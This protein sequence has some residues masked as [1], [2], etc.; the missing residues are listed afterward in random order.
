MPDL[1]HI[2]KTYT[3]LTPGVVAVNDNHLHARV[4]RTLDEWYADVDDELDP[5]P[6]NPLWSGSYTSQPAAIEA[7]CARLAAL[8]RQPT[9][10]T[11]QAS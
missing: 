4:F 2:L 9:Y 11:D 10:L 6:D 7:A 8:H 3:V 5:Q 1:R